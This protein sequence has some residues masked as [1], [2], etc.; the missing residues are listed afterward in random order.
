MPSQLPD[1]PPLMLLE[2]DEEVGGAIV[3]GRF[4]FVIRAISELRSR[5]I[6][7]FHLFLDGCSERW[8]CI[9]RFT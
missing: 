5:R 3:A 9:G 8:L 1:I 4:D 2:T 7:V 6:R